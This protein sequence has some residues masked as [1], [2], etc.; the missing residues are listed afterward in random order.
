MRGVL[1]P[2]RWLVLSLGGALIGVM[3]LTPADASTGTRLKVYVGYMDTHTAASS[4]RQPDPWPFRQPRHFVGSPCAHYKTS[5]HC[6]DASAVRLD[7]RGPRPVR[8][9]VTV[10]IGKHVYDLWGRRLIRP[11]TRLVLTETGPRNSQNFDGSDFTPNDY[12]GGYRASCKNSGAIPRVRVRI[13][14]TT[15]V[16]RDR[17]QVLN[18]GGVDAGHCVD[19]H[20]VAERR[21]ESHPWARVWVHRRRP[22]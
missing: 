15:R 6:W 20:Y 18:T 4:R 12:D 19:G 22:R 17:A 8:V 1:G 7:N 2:L 3:L 13:G 11:G 9:H 16:Y 21:D 5:I 14:R 10:L